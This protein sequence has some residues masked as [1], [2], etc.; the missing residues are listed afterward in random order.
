[1]GKKDYN[2]IDLI[3]LLI[4]IFF[5]FVGLR[6]GFWQYFLELVLTAVSLGLAWVYYQHSQEIFKSILVFILV[7]LGLLFLKW[8]LLRGKQKGL[9]Q[10][11]P[12]SFLNRFLG[13]GVGISWGILIAVLFVLTLD[14]LATQTVFKYNIQQVIQTS[15][16][17]Q[18]VH[19]L[20]PRKRI[21]IIEDIRYLNRISRDEAARAKYIEQPQVKEL[22]EL[23]SLKAIIQD[24][25]TSQQLQEQNF[26]KL[27][28]NP[29]ILNLLNDRQ[30]LEKLLN[31]DIKK[32]SGE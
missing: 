28:L 14:I 27:L 9:S 25:Q 24:P 18:I 32:L 4:I 8:L 5:A 21:R 22:L 11:S 7:S 30:F 1:M 13:A 31:L 10:E 26:P 6:K 23:E 19:R 2:V 15:Q 3:V 17:C 16:A 12:L 20:I 29:K